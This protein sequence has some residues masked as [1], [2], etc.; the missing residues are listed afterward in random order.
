M[1]IVIRISGRV[2]VPRSVRETLFRMRLRKKYTAILIENKEENI[3]MLDKVRNFVAYGIIKKE[4][5]E[6]LIELRGEL[7]DKRKKI[8]KENIIAEIGKKPL[9]E[10]GIKPFFRLHPPRGGIDSKLHFPI[11]KG[12]LGD[13]G[14]KINLLLER[15]L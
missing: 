7:M 13:N 14:E 2:E 10:L 4:M 3:I 5:L 8:S 6:K 15:M 9:S 11:R 12:V 1:I